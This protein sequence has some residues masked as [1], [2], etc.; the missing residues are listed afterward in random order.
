MA[1]EFPLYLKK[2]LGIRTF[3]LVKVLFTCIFIR[4]KVLYRA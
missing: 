2:V 1:D 3:I 4:I